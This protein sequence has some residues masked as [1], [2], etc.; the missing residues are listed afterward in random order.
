MAKSTVDKKAV[1]AELEADSRDITHLW[2]TAVKQYTDVTK[3]TLVAPHFVDTASMI[4]FGTEEMNKFHHFRHDG[5]KVDR[6]RRLFVK[7]I[8]YIEIGST[9]LL[10]A[11]SAA[12]PPAAA[13]STAMT[14]I[15]SA[16]R[17]VSTEYDVIIN[18]FEDMNNFLDR[19]TIIEKRVPRQKAYQNA[20]MD[21]FISLLQMCAIAHK[22][23]EQKRFSK[24]CW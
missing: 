20:L 8:E 18:F 17:A 7:N 9:V 10:N 13:I 24:N 4:N 2:N 15:L 19:V 1:K 5:K 12:F 23:I 14:F 22:F 6:L 3:I 11:A 16:C 21:V